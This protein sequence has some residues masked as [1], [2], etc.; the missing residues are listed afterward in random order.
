M[1]EFW[2]RGY[3]KPIT[4]EIYQELVGQLD[5]IKDKAAQIANWKLGYENDEVC[6]SDCTELDTHNIYFQYKTSGCDNCATTH[7]VVIPNKA[8]WAQDEY[9]QEWR[10]LQQREREIKEKQ[11][12][13][14]KREQQKTEQQKRYEQFL[15]LREEFESVGD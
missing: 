8:L 7:E 3:K 10:E 12:E 15:K 11:R 1:N 6:A 9:R 2:E 13:E 5:Q 14:Q 4:F